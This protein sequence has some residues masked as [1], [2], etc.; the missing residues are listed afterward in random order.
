[1]GL[2]ACG[3]VCVCKCVCASDI[4]ADNYRLGVCG[5]FVGRGGGGG[6]NFRENSYT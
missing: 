6:G 2:V 1:M 5:R 3:D 4:Y